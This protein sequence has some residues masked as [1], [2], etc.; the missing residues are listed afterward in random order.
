MAKRKMGA[1]SHFRA[2]KMHVKML[3][4]TSAVAMLQYREKEA[5]LRLT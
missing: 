1:A 3:I 5:D 2:H 4:L